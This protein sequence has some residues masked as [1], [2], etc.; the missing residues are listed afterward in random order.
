MVVV[1]VAS[2]VLVQCQSATSSGGLSQPLAQD[3]GREAAALIPAAR[4]GECHGRTELQWRGS[5]HA[6]ADA[7][8]LYRAMRI[9]A[10]TT[11]CDRCHAPLRQIAAADP[12]AA[13]GVNCDV[14]H[15]IASV[16]VGRVGGAGFT[17]RVDDAVRYGPLCDAKPHYFHS[18]GC[19][20]LHQA[21]EFCAACH[22]WSVKLPSGAALA[23][24]P[25]Y[26]EWLEDSA[27]G[28]GLPCQRC[29]MPGERAEVAVGWPERFGVP[30]HTFLG[31]GDLRRRALTGRARITSSAGR[32]TVN[33]SLTNSGAGH[34]I[35]TGLPERQLRVEVELV[36]SFGRVTAR[37]EQRYGRMLVDDAG[38][39]VP[40]YEA[41]RELADTRIRAGETRQDSFVLP[42]AGGE[43]LRMSVTWRPI[44]PTLAARLGVTAPPDEP[45]LSAGLQ[46]PARGR[47][48]ATVVELSP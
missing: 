31:R 36:D 37:K 6:R 22:D 18:M 13:E 28:S 43:R 34:A 17:L 41:T 9:G 12:V 46:L 32:L 19:S 20:P 11:S 48:E 38:K 2:G 8:P 30:M 26:R 27:G 4:C 16:Q 5:A 45:V 47:G 33:V 29:H 25:E 14:C 21:G 7:S 10:R 3:L 15:T 1:V 24:Y 23:I 44:S 40:F 42:A 39:E 35:P